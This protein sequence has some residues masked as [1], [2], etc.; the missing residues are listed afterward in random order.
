MKSDERNDLVVVGALKCVLCHAEAQRLETVV[1][2]H[3]RG[4]MREWSTVGHRS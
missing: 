1:Q 4:V 2:I 3:F